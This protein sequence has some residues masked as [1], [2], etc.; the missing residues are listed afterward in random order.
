MAASKPFSLPYGGNLFPYELVP[1]LL[2]SS[3][4]RMRM[5]GAFS[6]RVSVASPTAQSAPS[7]KK[8]KKSERSISTSSPT[9]TEN[10]EF[11]DVSP[12]QQQFFIPECLPSGLYPDNSSLSFDAESIFSNEL[13]Q[14]HGSSL[15]R[16]REDDVLLVL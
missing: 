4:E 6:S 8:A 9:L 13:Q 11:D 1:R 15:K 5:F 3:S 14:T 7:P 12:I 10:S 16:S 2:L